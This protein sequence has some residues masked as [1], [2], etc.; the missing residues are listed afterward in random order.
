MLHHQSLSSRSANQA[1]PRRAY[2][3]REACAAL[4]GISSSTLDRWLRSGKLR[5]IKPAGGIVLIPADEIE[6]FLASIGESEAAN[7]G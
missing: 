3:K 5:A 2:K 4:G 6:R 1:T 7:A